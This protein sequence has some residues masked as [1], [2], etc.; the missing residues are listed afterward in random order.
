MQLKSYLFCYSE[1]TGGREAIKEWLASGVNIKHWR[2][3]MP[4]CFYLV[5]ELSADDISK[6]FQEFNGR[7]GRHLVTEI[8]RNKQGLLP[9]DSWHLINKKEKAPTE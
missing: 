2:Y 6:S 3:D 8:S 5:S 1:K 9:K 7:K 4:Y